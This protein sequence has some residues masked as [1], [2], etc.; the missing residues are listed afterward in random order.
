MPESVVA[1]SDVAPS[2]VAASCGPASVGSPPSCPASVPASPDEGAL[3]SVWVDEQLYPHAPPEHTCPEGHVV[4]HAPQ[5]VLLVLVLTHMPLHT[6]WPVGQL[7]PQTP[8]AHT[9]S[10]VHALPHAPQF[11]GSVIVSTHVPPS[12]PHDVC[13][14]GHVVDCPP[15]VSALPPVAQPIATTV[16]NSKSAEHSDRGSKRRE[17]ECIVV[18]SDTNRTT[19]GPRNYSSPR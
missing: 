12:A 14:V 16:T 17:R 10:L 8:A 2:L 19:G 4:P 18:S 6:T 5:F 15:P 1:A 11:A 7:S 13:D 9:W 3:Q